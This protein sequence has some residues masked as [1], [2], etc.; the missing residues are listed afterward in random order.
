V[1]LVLAE[2]V[3]EIFWATLNG[4][5]SQLVARPGAE[6]LAKLCGLLEHFDGGHISPTLFSS[7]TTASVSASP[8]GPSE[9]VIF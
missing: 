5:K 8:S 6:T 1:P 7:P 2:R 4:L 3:E 9:G